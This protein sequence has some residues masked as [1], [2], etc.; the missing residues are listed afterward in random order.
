MK[1]RFIVILVFLLH[2]TSAFAQETETY[3]VKRNP[4]KV[5]LTPYTNSDI[6]IFR[7]SGLFENARKVI[8]L[9]T[10]NGYQAQ[11][12]KALEMQETNHLY[13]FCM[14][15]PNDEAPENTICVNSARKSDYG[16]LEKFENRVVKDP[17]YLDKN[18]KKW[19]MGKESYLT[20][21]TKEK[22]K[23][24]DSYKVKIKVKDRNLI[25]QFIVLE[26][27]KSFLFINY[28]AGQDSFKSDGK[29]FAK[30]MKK[31]KL[32]NQKSSN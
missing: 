27:A 14:T 22:Y 5:I 32:L 20:S 7:V 28:I 2:L 30:F 19:I 17:K 26:T 18:P 9:D 29:H 12:P 8:Y 1:P 4:G 25:G 13:N 21:V 15:V 11:V 31:F 16:T 6:V 24:Y 10:I 23:S 3:R